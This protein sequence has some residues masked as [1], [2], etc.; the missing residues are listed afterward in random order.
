MKVLIFGA[1]GSVGSH[2]V[3]QALGQGH[4]VTTFVRDP[5]KLGDA[6]AEVRILRGDVMDA[7]AVEGAVAGQDAVLCSLGAGRKGEV[8][9]AGTLNIVRAMKKEG[10][11][12][13]VCQT[14]LG[15]GDS[16]GNLNFFW[17]HIMFGLLLREA[18]ADHERQEDYV[19]QSGLDWTLVRPGAF[20]DGKRTGVYRHGFPGTE[21]GISLKISRA[22]VAD[23]MLKQLVDDTYVRATPGLSY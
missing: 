22:D 2:L 7:A 4:D 9:S 15:V 23:F 1:T 6:R 14:T 16:S 8:R 19:R 3:E 13:L 5:A 11:R 12:R 18:F 21:K 20:A 10:V 17:K